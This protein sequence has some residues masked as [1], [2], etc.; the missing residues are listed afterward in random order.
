[1]LDN[2]GP[3]FMVLAMA[4]LALAV[5]LAISYVFMHIL[6]REAYI[7]NRKIFTKKRSLLLLFLMIGYIIFY[8]LGMYLVN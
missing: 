4:L 8:A 3:I 6:N 7:S 1:M 2:F 5:L